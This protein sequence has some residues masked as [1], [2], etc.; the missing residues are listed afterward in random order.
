MEARTQTDLAPRAFP[1]WQHVDYT[2]N[3][4]QGRMRRNTDQHCKEQQH[5]L[6]QWGSWS[7]TYPPPHSYTYGMMTDTTPCPNHNG[8]YFACGPVPYHDRQ[9]IESHSRQRMR[10]WLEA[11]INSG[12]IPDLNWIDKHSKIFKVPWKHGGKHDW[13]ESAAQIFKE[14]AVHTGRFREGVDEPDFPTWKTRFR[15]AL[16]KLPDIQ[17]LK[18]Q[19][20][21]DDP[22]PFRVYQFQQLGKVMSQSY[23]EVNKCKVPLKIPTTVDD[24]YDSGEKKTI[25]LDSD[26]KAID[27]LDLV[28]YPSEAAAQIKQ[29]ETDMDTTDGSMAQRA[30]DASLEVDPLPYNTN[31]TTGAPLQSQIQTLSSNIEVEPGAH[32]MYIQIRYRN[33]EV[34]LYKVQSRGGCRVYSGPNASG[35]MTGDLEEKVYGSTQA[36][37]LVLPMSDSYLGNQKQR[38]LTLQLLNVMDRGVLFENEGGN[39]YATRK[40]RCVIFVALPHEN[41]L[42]KKLVR[43]EKVMIFDYKSHFRNSLNKYLMGTGPKPAAHVLLSFGQSFQHETRMPYTNLLISATIFH[44]NAYHELEK[45]NCTFPVSPPIQISKSDDYDKLLDCMKITTTPMMMNC[46]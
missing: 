7:S 14:W 2:R 27:V 38:S 8:M 25:S 22:N 19:S 29:E 23:A 41:G 16:N 3:P 34:I 17:E 4:P 18:E 12:E 15:C 42:V 32:M 21:L 40:C 20:Q 1:D 26:L 36:E 44:A 35:G 30:T 33:I 31:P 45:I 6:D 43:E 46:P 9:S 28:T 39:I 11:R 37:E 5:C 10:P 13:K 24:T